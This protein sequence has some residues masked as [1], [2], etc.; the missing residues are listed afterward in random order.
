MRTTY[1]LVVACHSLYFDL[2]I[3]VLSLVTFFALTLTL[4]ISPINNCLQNSGQRVRRVKMIYS[5]KHLL[6]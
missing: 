2:F 3:I 6:V 4:S 1:L 5:W